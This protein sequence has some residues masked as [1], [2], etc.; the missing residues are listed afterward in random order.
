MRKVI[1]A[2]FCFI[3][4]TQISYAHAP[5]KIETSFDYHTGTISAIITHPVDDPESHF[6]Q[7]VRILI[8]DE[9]LLEDTFTRQDNKENHTISYVINAELREGDKIRVEAYCNKGGMTQEERA[10]R[11]L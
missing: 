3:L 7:K 5:S 2:I 9:L 4:I 1:L 8:N 11:L 6:I 10:L